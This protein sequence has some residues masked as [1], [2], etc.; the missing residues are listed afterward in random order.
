MFRRTLVGCLLEV[1]TLRV[2]ILFLLVM[3]T[4]CANLCIYTLNVTVLALLYTLYCIFY[5]VICYSFYCRPCYTLQSPLH[6]V[7]LW[8]A[9]LQVLL[10][11][12]LRTLQAIQLSVLF[13]L[14]PA[15]N[16][17]GSAA[18]WLWLVIHILKCILFLHVFVCNCPEV[19]QL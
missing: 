3:N 16:P 4:F 18:G 2:C 1:F 13:L 7:S 9:V 14:R 6:D 11:V 10:K 15:S 12:L 19:V 8:R 5:W 17:A